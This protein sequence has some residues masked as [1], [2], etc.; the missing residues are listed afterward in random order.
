MT[1]R[2]EITRTWYYIESDESD[3]WATDPHRIE[4]SEM[5]YDAEEQETYE[6][7]VEWAVGMLNND[8]IVATPNMAGFPDLEPSS[9]PIGDRARVHEWLSGTAG[10]NYTNEE[11]A[12]SIRLVSPEW[13]EEMRAEVFRRATG[14]S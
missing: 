1:F 6:T 11:S 10:D 8:S 9:S 7:A 3:S 12:W 13:T 4:H 14:M 5:E 2:M